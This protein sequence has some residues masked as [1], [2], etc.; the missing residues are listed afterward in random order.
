MSL[1]QQIEQDLKAA[2]LAGDKVLATTLRGIKSTILNTEI[3][4]GSREQG[5][6]DD[7]IIAV[8]QKE[9]KRRQESADLYEQGGRPDK[10]KAEQEEKAVI[11]KYLPD[12]LSEEEIAEAVETAINATGA[13]GLQSMGQVIGSVKQKLGAGADGSLIARIVKEKLQ[14]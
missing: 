7:Q 9:A 1:K 13:T 6:L 4:Q 8:L 2:M 12:Q 10:A 3:A 11:E 14:P 5:L